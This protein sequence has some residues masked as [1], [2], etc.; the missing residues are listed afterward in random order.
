MRPTHILW[1]VSNRKN[2]QIA[3][4]GSLE[5]C[6]KAMER[7]DWEGLEIHQN[8]IKESW[9]NPITEIHY[10]LYMDGTTES[11]PMTELELKAE[12]IF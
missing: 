12:G 11:R 5:D 10:D 1:D 8:E 6:Q 3:A 7:L 9:C 4:K 2:W